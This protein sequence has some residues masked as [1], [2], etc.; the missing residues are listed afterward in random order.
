MY[1]Y[2]ATTVYI[3]QPQ[4]LKT[5][6]PSLIIPPTRVTGR[7]EGSLLLLAVQSQPSLI[8]SQIQLRYA[9]AEPVL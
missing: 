6:R 2:T 4:N 1:W 3:D 7:P 9:K 8:I 5:K